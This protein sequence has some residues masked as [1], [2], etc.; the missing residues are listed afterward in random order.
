M[1]EENAILDKKEQLNEDL[2]D[3]FDFDELE[4]KLQ[5]QLEEELADMQFL[6]EEKEKI[7]LQ[8]ALETLHGCSP[9]GQERIR[10]LR[11]YAPGFLERCAGA[12]RE[13]CRFPTENK[14]TLTRVTRLLPT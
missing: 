14:P 9:F 12:A 6:A 7:G 13:S 1:A 5:S 4:E 3:S 2:T 10:R 11:F 8:Y